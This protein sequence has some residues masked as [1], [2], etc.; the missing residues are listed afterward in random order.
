MT[1]RIGVI[2]CHLQ[3][4]NNRSVTNA[5]A[6]LRALLV[7]TIR[8]TWLL[9]GCQ[10]SQRR[11]SPENQKNGDDPPQGIHGGDY[12]GPGCV[13]QFVNARIAFR[14]GTRY[15]SSPDNVI[16]QHH[17]GGINENSKIDR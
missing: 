8:T 5:R 2:S 4:R 9:V 6:V 11:R 15:I 16:E 1:D 7:M 17:E 14:T 13:R 12:T 10:R 3:C